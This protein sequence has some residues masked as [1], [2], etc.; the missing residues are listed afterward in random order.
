MQKCLPL[1]NL[2]SL[3][4]KTR[5][6]LDMVKYIAAIDQGTTSTRFMVF[7]LKGNVIAS[8]QIPLTQI[9]PQ[10]GWV[11]QDPLEILQTVQVCID[12]TANKMTKMGLRIQDICSIGLTNQRETTVVWDKTTGQPLHNAI[13]WLD[14]RTKET[15]EKLTRNHSKNHLQSI[16]GLPISTYFSAVKLRWLLDNVD[17]VQRARK[18]DRL[19]FGTIDSW[20]IYKLCSNNGCGPHVTDV[21]NASRTMLMNIH[22]RQWDSQLLE[23]FD[24]SESLL[25]K[26]QS[27]SQVY[28]H[29]TTGL[30][31]GTPLS[32]CLGDQQAALVGQR[33]LK[34]GNVK[35]TYGTGCFLLYNTGN[36]PVFSK[37][38]LLTTVAY[39]FGTEEPVYALEGSVAIAGAAIN[40][41]R[42]N[43]GLIKEPSEISVLASQVSDSAGVF[44]VPAFSGLFAVR[45]EF[46]YISAL[47]ERRC[48]R[49]HYWFDSIFNKGAY[50]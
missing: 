20:L 35:S 37:H 46:I 9:Y 3:K 17:S 47:L 28:G 30:L 13:V 8:H 31:E 48:T 4:T 19:L 32:G 29:L 14:T 24:I 6:I 16:C 15:V 21:T 40:W 50:L 36:K 11:E 12:E 49:M 34:I 10:A 2:F 33:C 44:F 7:D 43:M 41:L 45:I 27:S 1:R 22:S 25:P 18:D 26:I 39:Q 23:F 42:D 38:G 5:S